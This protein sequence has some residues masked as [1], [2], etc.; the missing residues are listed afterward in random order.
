MDVLSR[1]ILGAGMSHLFDRDRR[2]TYALHLW[3]G[4]QT[5]EIEVSITAASLTITLHPQRC[6]V[7]TRSTDNVSLDRTLDLISP[8][9]DRTGAAV[10]YGHLALRRTSTMVRSVF[11]GVRRLKKNAIHYMHR[12]TLSISRKEV[13]VEAVK[14]LH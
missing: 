7:A 8:G 12:F 9:G 13:P 6:Q 2:C 10:R 3:G 1:L 11:G 5:I 4:Y 14:E